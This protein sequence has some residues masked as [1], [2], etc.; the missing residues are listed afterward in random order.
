M[1]RILYSSL[2]NPPSTVDYNLATGEDPRPVRESAGW[3]S[4]AACCGCE[5][6]VDGHRQSLPLRAMRLPQV[7]RHVGPSAVTTASLV[8]LAG[9]RLTKQEQEV[10]GGYDREAFTCAFFPQ[11]VTQHAAHPRSCCGLEHCCCTSL[12]P[13]R[14]SAS[15]SLGQPACIRSLMPQ[16]LSTECR[17]CRS[18]RL[19]ARAEDGVLIPYSLVYR[20]D[21]LRVSGAA[22][23]TIL[24]AYGA[25]MLLAPQPP[26]HA[27]PTATW[28]CEHQPLP[29]RTPR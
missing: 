4:A 22:S 15:Q 9:E 17:Q 11:P 6:R 2:V 13:S 20:K 16:A 29:S 3:Y 7:G 18:E 27:R 26:D 28:S 8:S 21:L 10:A 5:G 25:P 1:L 24:E 19:W 23:P 14:P 12:R